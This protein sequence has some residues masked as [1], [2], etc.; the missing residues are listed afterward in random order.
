PAVSFDKIPGKEALTRYAGSGIP[1]LVVVDTNGKV[2]FDTFAGTNYRGPS[3][4]LSELN[5]LFGSSAGG[6]KIAVAR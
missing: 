4:V 2:V 1:C 3:A 6:G 5:Q